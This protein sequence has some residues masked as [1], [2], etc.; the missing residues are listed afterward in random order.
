VSPDQPAVTVG[1]PV[2][3]GDAFLDECLQSLCA[4]TFSNFELLVCDNASTDRTAAI[5]QSHAR[6]D[7]RIR[8]LRAERNAGAAANFNLPLAHARAPLFKW[9][10]HDDRC[11][12]TFLARC[13]EALDR[14]PAAVG[15]YPETVDID[16]EGRVVRRWAPTPAT[17]SADVVERCWTLLTHGNESF[18]FFGVLRTETLRRIRP[19]GGYPAADRIL[20]VGLGL[21][22]PLVQV[23]EPLFEH[24]EH[25]GRSV[26]AVGASH[27]SLTWWDPVRAVRFPYWCFAT[28][29]ATAIAEGPLPPIQRLRAMSL[30]LRWAAENNYWAK[31]LYDIAVPLRP[32]LDRIWQ[33]RLGI[34]P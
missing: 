10:A 8:Y 22:G 26:R 7:P 15:A 5:A 6:R 21:R 31:L 29:L 28:E 23:G 19:L 27:G 16:A 1:V 24:R 25:P 14:N 11:G 18:P 2:F 4:Q 13:V 3:N 20:L 17:A 32:V 33:L 9:A 12:P 34:R 30:L